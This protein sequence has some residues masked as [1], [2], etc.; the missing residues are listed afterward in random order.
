MRL[1][2]FRVTKYRNVIDS[3]TIAVSPLTVLVGKNESG[4]TTLL[5]ALHKLNPFA[6]DPYSIEREW[7]RGRRKG[8]DP[9][10]VVCQVRLVPSPEEMADLRAITDVDIAEPEFTVSRNY[11]DQLRIDLSPEE[12]PSR[13][14]KETLRRI[15][16]EKLAIPEPV[17]DS[18][19]QAAKQL[20]DE[21]TQAALDG[22]LKDLIISEGIG[23]ARY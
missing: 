15:C 18:F 11:A 21:V 13:P 7:P 9:Q 12:F 6:G 20:T 17:G 5:R 8:R 1:V 14:T 10:Q 2:E 3:G 4:K 23:F 19:R 16:S 22:R